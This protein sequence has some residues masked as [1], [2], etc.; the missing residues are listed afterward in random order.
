[1]HGPGQEE[2]RRAHRVAQGRARDLCEDPGH[3]LTFVLPCESCLLYPVNA[4]NDGR[5]RVC[6]RGMAG[7][8]LDRLADG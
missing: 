8:A 5:A 2:Q 7:P 6:Y 1:M 3:Q 4:V